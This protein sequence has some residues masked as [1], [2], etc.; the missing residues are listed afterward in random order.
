MSRRPPWRTG[1]EP[2]PRGR[3]A[4]R[5]HHVS[6]DPRR[7]DGTWRLPPP[8]RTPGERAGRAAFT[9]LCLGAALAALVAV[10]Q[11]PLSMVAV[12]VPPAAH[13]LWF[14]LAATAAGYIALSLWYCLPGMTRALRCLAAAPGI[15]LV[16]VGRPPGRGDDH[17]PQFA[18]GWFADGTQAV[19]AMALFLTLGAGLVLWAGVRG[20][21]LRASAPGAGKSVEHGAPPVR[22]KGMDTDTRRTERTRQGSSH[23]RRPRI[24]VVAAL[25]WAALLGIVIVDLIGLLSA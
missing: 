15:L 11:T 23:H 18:T 12:T 14:A 2:P 20:P 21:R 16:V 3:R 19:V 22:H 24:T 17:V 13:G 10:N 6:G 1:G 4:R 8:R 25:I 7:R 9:T 5:R